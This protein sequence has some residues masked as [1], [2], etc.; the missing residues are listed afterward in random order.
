MYLE[1]QTL[2]CTNLCFLAGGGVEGNDC[3][4]PNMPL[5]DQGGVVGGVARH[6]SVICWKG[7][8]AVVS[9]AMPG[10]GGGSEDAAELRDRGNRSTDAQIR[11]PLLYLLE[12]RDEAAESALVLWLPEE[13]A[14]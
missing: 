5:A 13:E 2:H 12:L 4:L 7:G 8:P 10:D 3:F 11:E 9:P 1:V 6:R 14:A